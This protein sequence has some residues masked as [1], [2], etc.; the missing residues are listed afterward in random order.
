MSHKLCL[1]AAALALSLASMSAHAETKVLAKAN[2][3]QAFGGT[4]AKGVPVCGISVAPE[5]RY[6]GLKFFSGDKTFTIQMSDKAW[7][8]SDRRKYRLTM[9]FDDRDEWSATGAGMHFND[10]DPGLEYEI[11]S[12][13]LKNFAREFGG[14]RRLRLHFRDDGMDD[15]SLDLN[16][17]DAVRDEFEACRR[18]LQERG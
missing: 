1:A 10:G 9:R 17:V 2:G 6:F 11:R 5:G 13:E 15:W 7:D 18:R 12:E 4:T 16:G 3:W 14:S 8:V